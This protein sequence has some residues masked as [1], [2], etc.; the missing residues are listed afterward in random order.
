M[1]STAAS[2]LADSPEYESKAGK[3]EKKEKIQKLGLA[4][5]FT[6]EAS[7][8]RILNTQRILKFS[9]FDLLRQAHCLAVSFVHQHARAAVTACTKAGYD[10]VLDL[11]TSW[12]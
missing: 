4:K 8:I 10:I 6:Q 1:A 9:F 5:E 2:L 12:S 3:R 11:C 7:D